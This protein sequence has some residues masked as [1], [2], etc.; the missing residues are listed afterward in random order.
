MLDVALDFITFVA[1][2]MIIAYVVYDL[3]ELALT[4]R[5]SMTAYIASLGSVIYL[6]GV[7]MEI[8]IPRWNA[9]L[10]LAFR[11]VGIALILLPIIIARVSAGIEQ[12]A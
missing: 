2:A 11:V 10:D 1:R 7:W 4:A 5:P 8:M 6:L 12:E 3:V 9:D